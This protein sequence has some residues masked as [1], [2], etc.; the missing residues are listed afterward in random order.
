[1][2]HPLLAHRSIIACWARESSA[3]NTRQMRGMRRAWPGDFDDSMAQAIRGIFAVM[4]GGILRN[5]PKLEAKAPRAIR[6]AE[7]LLPT[8]HAGAAGVGAEVAPRQGLRC[9]TFCAALK[10]P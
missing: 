1:M 9:K 2:A 3:A 7:R 10:L 4:H 6:R 5:A 8:G